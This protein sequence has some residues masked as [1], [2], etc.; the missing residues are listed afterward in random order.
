MLKMVQWFIDEG[1]KRGRDEEK[2]LIAKKLI[3]QNMP[4][5]FV[6]KLTE[7]DAATVEGPRIE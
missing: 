5:R 2:L 4:T 1:E 6:T 3:L 7:L